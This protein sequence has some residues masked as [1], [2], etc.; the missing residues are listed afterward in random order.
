LKWRRS[1]VARRGG[2]GAAGRSP[3]VSSE[4][5]EDFIGRL[6]MG[7]A[8]ALRLEREGRAV[9]SARAAYPYR[10][11]LHPFGQAWS[12]TEA[13]RCWSNRRKFRSPISIRCFPRHR[14]RGI[15]Q[16]RLTAGGP[17]HDFSLDGKIETTNLDIA[18]ADKVEVLAKSDIRLSGSRAHPVIKGEMEIK[19][20]LIRVPDMPKNLHAREGQAFLWSDSITTAPVDTTS[21]LGAAA[22]TTTP[23]EKR[24]FAGEIDVSIRIPSEFWIRG[25][26]LNIELAGDLNVQEKNGM[27]FIKGQLRAIRGISL[28]WA[29]RSSWKGE[30][31][32]STGGTRPT[33]PWTSP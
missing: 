8:A 28:F 11:S 4:L 33:H 19:R 9:L 5:A 10:V 12:M 29:G 2:F 23:E 27:P 20:G 22:E 32:L 14:A 16:D 30:R 18:V 26:G 3:R 21:A 24:R 17:V 13:S 6:R 31:C 1:W 7:L 25:K 15:R